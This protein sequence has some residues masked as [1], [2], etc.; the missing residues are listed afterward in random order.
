MT[1]GRIDVLIVGA[2]AA[3]LAAAQELS[4]GG[5][6]VV[7]LEARARAG[8]RVFTR[9]ARAWPLPIELGAEF[10][11]GRNDEIFA[12]ARDGGFLIDR[13]P[14]VTFEVSDSGWK[15]M[16][17]LWKKVDAIT[18]VM[19]PDGRDRSVAEFLESRRTLSSEQKRLMRGIVEG[20]HAA[21]PD[22]ASEHALS[23]AGEPVDE[24]EGS[25][26]RVVSGYDRVIDRLR[27]GVDPKRCRLLISTPVARIRWKRGDV[28]VRTAKGRDLRAR[29]AIVTVPV[30][31]LKQDA[32]AKG[33][34]E[35]DPDPPALR[36]ALAGIETGHVVK[37]ALRFRE[38]FWEDGPSRRGAQ[39]AFLHQW[40]APYPTWWTAAPAEVPMLTAWAG[41]PAAEAL[42]RLPDAVRLDRALETLGSLFDIRA[43]KLRR[44]LLAWHAHDWNADPYSRGAYS[45]VGVGGANAPRALARPIDGTLY[46][47]GEATEPDQNGT[48]PG[49]IASGRRV[50]RLILEA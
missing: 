27:S 16:R 38:Q 37:I 9:R 44:L 7:V 39:F 2:G 8:G 35:L 49:A 36:R 19:R 50:A 42:S 14:D 22:R 18:R 23:T 43:A 31:V 28:Q 11:H 4:L 17:D 13:L 26:F 24:D 25:Q 40:G 12:I 48:V 29:R 6:S 34:I 33:G 20:Y 41:G 15:R 10:V 5:A 47:A 3:G 45:Y 30:G 46:F 1:K 21:S 32:G